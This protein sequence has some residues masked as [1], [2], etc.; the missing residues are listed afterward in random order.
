MSEEPLSATEVRRHIWESLVSML[1]VYAHAASLGSD[2]YGVSSNAVSAW[3]TY[4]TSAL[5]ISYSPATGAAQWRLEKA[6]HDAQ[7]EFEI[8]HDGRLL[9]PQG[10]VELD[11]A[12]ID[13]V[14]QLGPSPCAV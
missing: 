4:E 3:V 5:H 8:D 2:A 13:W 7:G 11:A 12:A 6:G 14:Q 10:P 9:F 1:R